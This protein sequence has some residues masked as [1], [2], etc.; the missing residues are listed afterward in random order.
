MNELLKF[1]SG[2]FVCWFVVC[3]AYVRERG[4]VFALIGEEPGDR[5]PAERSQKDA[6][7]GVASRL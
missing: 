4:L 5:V 2:C 7:L 6:Q 3:C 1:C